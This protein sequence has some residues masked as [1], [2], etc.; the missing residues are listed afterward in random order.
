MNAVA[1]IFFVRV[2]LTCF[3]NPEQAP[4]RP[5][6]PFDGAPVRPPPPVE[7]DDE[8][9]VFKTA[10]LPSQPIMV[11]NLFLKISCIVMSRF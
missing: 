10:P 8:D 5:P 4:P 2:F 1:T 9:E 3:K 6:L 11:R 7:T